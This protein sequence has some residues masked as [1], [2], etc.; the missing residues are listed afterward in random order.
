MIDRRLL[1]VVSTAR[2]G[3]FT[4]AAERVGVTQS[5]ITK[6]V[7]DLERELGYSIFNRTARGVLLT[8][9]GRSFVE[10]ASRLLDEAK[11]LMRG[12]SA[13]SDP[14]SGTLKIGVCPAS[15]EWLLVEPLSTLMARH[16][17]IRLDIVGGSYDKVVQHLRSGTVDVAFGYQVAFEDQPDFRREPLAP[18]RTT[19]FVRQG[20]PILDCAEVT[21]A[22]IARYTLISPSGSSPYDYSWRQIYEEAGVDGNDRIHV[23]DFFPIVERLVRNSD[24]I[25]I[26]SVHYAETS[27]FKKR[28]ACV[29]FLLGTLPPSPLCCATRLR[30][31]P[32]PAV[33]AFIKAC[34][35]QL[36][37]SDATTAA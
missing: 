14:Y 1:Y 26:V 8:E 28:Y 18:L 2:Y 29:P 31:S 30:W 35:E 4:A 23:V 27:M 32:R 7:A 9:E 34:R 25:G 37:A 3:S 33:R 20:H 19:F 21:G 15:L 5:A 16:P 24:A 12:A 17:T 13:G 10:R 36:P 6:S 22:D 11:D